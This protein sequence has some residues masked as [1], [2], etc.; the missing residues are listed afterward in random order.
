MRSYERNN[1]PKGCAFCVQARNLRAA[2]DRPSLFRRF[3]EIGKDKRMGLEVPGF[4]FTARCSKRHFVH[5]FARPK[6]RTKK[7]APFPKVFFKVQAQT[8]KNRHKKR[9]YELLKYFLI[10]PSCA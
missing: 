3:C 1:Y 10:V 5:F 8:L 2:N 6:K 9:S 4:K 7:S